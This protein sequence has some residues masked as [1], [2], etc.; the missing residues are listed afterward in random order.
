[1]IRALFVLFLLFSLPALAQPA[2]TTAAPN[3]I[4]C[5][6]QAVG[7]QSTDIVLGQQATGPARSNQTVKITL[8]Q[9]GVYASSATL[10]PN[11]TI[12]PSGTL[13]TPKVTLGGTLSSTALAV[14]SAATT[15]LMLNAGQTIALDASGV[16]TIKYDSGTGKLFYAVSGTNVFSV[17]ASGNVRAAG[18]ITGSTTP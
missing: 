6:S 13:T 4:A 1:M 12:L 3:A 17:D 15:A 14:N 5:Q 7:L 10:G 11:I 8:S 18:T 9:I 2:C 16:H